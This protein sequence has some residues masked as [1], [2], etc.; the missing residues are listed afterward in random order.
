M[1]ELWLWL[2]SKDSIAVL[3][4]LILLTPIAAVVCVQPAFILGRYFLIPIAFLYLLVARFFVRLGKQG[5]IGM[6]VALTCFVGFVVA[7]L[8][9][10]WTLISGGRA[11]YLAAIHDMRTT[12]LQ[13]E[14]KLGGN[15]DFQNSIRLQYL[16]STHPD[17]DYLR[18]E[19]GYLNA[20][21]SPD[22]LIFE[23]IDP[24]EKRPMSLTNISGR[25]Y[26]FFRY[27]Q[28]PPESGS[29]WYVYRRDGV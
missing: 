23:S 1:A 6:A 20:T 27:Y 25:T 18:Y 26:S 8:R 15:Q 12:L 5:K 13:G 16:L 21:P 22:F 4:L 3:I 14:L 7:N 19:S 29:Q 11:Q 24:H 28:A 17:L 10:T 9:T 2:R